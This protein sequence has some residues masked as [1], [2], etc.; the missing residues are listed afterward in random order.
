MSGGFRKM[1]KKLVYGPMA[2]IASPVFA[3]ISFL[4]YRY[5]QRKWEKQGWK[6]PGQS[7]IDF[8]RE[9]VTVI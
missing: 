1:A 4:K 2:P 9:N 5:F 3:L 8:V 7:E 6:K